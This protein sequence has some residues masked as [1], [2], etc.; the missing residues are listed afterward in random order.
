MPS[1]LAILGI[2]LAISVAGN[3]L[4]AKLYVGA[5]EDVAAITQK[6]SSFVAG[7]KVAGEK[8][9]KDAKDRTAAEKLSK[10]K[11]DAE[12]AKTAA[13]NAAAIAVV[14][15][16]RDSARSA[17]LS[18]TPPGSRCPDGQACFNRAEYQRAYGKLVADLRAIADEGTAVATDLNTARKWAQGATAH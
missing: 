18:S 14:R 9:E 10:E 3:A 17:F 8:A 13:A 4:L 11:A 7:V 6:H 12:N 2:L 1:P 15:H 16:Q 5:R